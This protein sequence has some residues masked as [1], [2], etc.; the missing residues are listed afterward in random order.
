ML[1]YCGFHI[2]NIMFAPMVSIIPGC[3]L[4]TGNRPIQSHGAPRFSRPRKIS[5]STSSEI[6]FPLP[7]DTRFDSGWRHFECEYF[8]FWSTQ[9]HSIHQNHIHLWI[10][11][12]PW[13]HW[14]KVKIK[15]RCRSRAWDRRTLNPQVYRLPTVLRVY[16]R[17]IL[18]ISSPE[19]TMWGRK[20][21]PL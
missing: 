12:N 13:E 4:V 2:S 10:V 7:P 16:S 14:S 20:P 9:G 6:G 11:S 8:S 1:P 5:M 15:P 21:E 3:F 18:F 17:T 19:L